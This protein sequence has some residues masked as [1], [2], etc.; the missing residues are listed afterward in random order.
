MNHSITT[1]DDQL[2]RV[3]G[4]IPVTDLELRFAI[5]DLIVEARTSVRIQTYNEFKPKTI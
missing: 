5:Y 3:D 1:L 2:K 4:L